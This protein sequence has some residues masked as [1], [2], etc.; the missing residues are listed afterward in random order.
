MFTAALYISRVVSSMAMSSMVPLV[1]ETI[2]EAVYPITEA[3]A[4][5]SLTLLKNW[6]VGVFLVVFFIPNIGNIHITYKPSQYLYVS[7]NIHTN[8]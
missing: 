5:G 1:F 3:V 7:I 4:N 2:C 6:W 8:M